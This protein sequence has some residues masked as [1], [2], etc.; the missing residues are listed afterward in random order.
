MEK[1]GLLITIEGPDAA[2]KKTQ[3]FML[4]NWLATREIKVSSM[5]FPDYTT[6]IGREIKAFLNN[7]RNYSAE[8]RHIL[9]AANRWERKG[10]ITKLLTEKNFL[11]VNRYTESN[12]VYGLANGLK[13][14]WLWNLEHGLPKPNLVFVL[15]VGIE[16]ILQRRKSR[17]KY[18]ADLTLQEKVRDIYIKL[19]KKHG[20][21][22]VNGS[23]PIEDVHKE[24]KEIVIRKFSSFVPALKEG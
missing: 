17:D 19:S 4:A 2:G 16:E 20:W 5:S 6:P 8:V 23:R 24:I 1:T 12:I 11:I 3:G 7:E 9:F 10:D 18:E 21:S 15:D 13:E 14:D 22:V